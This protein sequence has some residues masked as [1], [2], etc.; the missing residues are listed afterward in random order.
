MN[1]NYYSLLGVD[2]SADQETIKKAYRTL[3]KEHHPDTGGDE[4]KFKEINEAYSTL[5]VP[6]K[7]RVYDNPQPEGFPFGDM[8]G[9]FG[10]RP[11]FRPPDMNAPRQGKSIILEHAVSL[12]YFIFGGK[13][14]ISF[15]FRDSCPS[16]SGLGAEEKETCSD[17]NG[18]GHVVESRQNGNI[19]LQS[20]RACPKCNGRGFT[21]T[22]S[23]NSCS[24]SGTCMIEKNV[25]LE[26][27]IG[28]SPGQIVGVTGEGHIGLN[29]GANGDLAVKLHIS[30]PNLN[31]LTEEQKKVLK[32]L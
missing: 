4:E 30:M 3:S 6:E 29:G 26:I 23:C 5:S 21:A 19:F 2:K 31:E 18:V 11:P 12:R 15:S 9:G 13:L 10:P 28:V 17:C 14:P 1:K 24:G 8:F 32:G 22:K 16:C 7:R 20:S 27:P 25:E